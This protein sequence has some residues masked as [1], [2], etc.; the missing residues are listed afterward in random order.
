MQKRR[1]CARVAEVAAG[2]RAIPGS[3]A[4]V[5]RFLV[6]Q[7]QLECIPGVPRETARG[8]DCPLNKAAPR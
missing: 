8:I 2:R 4:S 3:F 6:R 5:E 7:A 1:L